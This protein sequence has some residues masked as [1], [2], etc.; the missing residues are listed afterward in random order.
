MF[1]QYRFTYPLSLKLDLQLTKTSLKSI[2][3]GGR[4]LSFLFFFHIFFSFFFFFFLNGAS[5]VPYWLVTHSRCCR[6]GGRAISDMFGAYRV[7]CRSE[8]LRENLS[9][10]F[11][12][13]RK[14]TVR[15]RA[16]ICRSLIYDSRTYGYRH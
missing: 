14:F 15:V 8:S 5:R 4:D 3:R 10:Q 12:F 16:D 9:L 7:S 2:I 1:E 6:Q 11:S 13:Q